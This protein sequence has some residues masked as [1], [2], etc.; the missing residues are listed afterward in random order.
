MRSRME[1][2]PKAPAWKFQ[3]ISIPGCATEQPITLYYRDSFEVLKML[4]SNPLLAGCIDFDV[5]K[6]YSSVDSGREYSEWVT[7]DGARFMQVYITSECQSRSIVKTNLLC[8]SHEFR[9]VVHSSA[10]YFPP[11]KPQ[12]RRCQETVLRTHCSS[13]SRISI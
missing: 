10:P 11:T 2:L 4:L 6:S 7:S 9:L 12:L 3:T 5:R 1:L 13:V 8:Y